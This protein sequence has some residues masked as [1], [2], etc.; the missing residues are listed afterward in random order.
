MTRRSKAALTLTLA[1]AAFLLAGC[2]PRTTIA[3]LNNDPGHYRDREVSIYGR[4]V[5]SFGAFGEGAYEVD[6]GTGRIWVLTTRG[7]VPG[8]GSRVRATGRV[9][10]GITFGGRTFGTVLRETDRHT[11]R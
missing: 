9:A 4:V 2:P 3:D 10:S 8:Q 1:F 7:G 5:T 6:D 11:Q